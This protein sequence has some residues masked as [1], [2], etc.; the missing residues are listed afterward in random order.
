MK[1]L[2]L[3]LFLVVSTVISH[4]FQL[5]DRPISI[6]T[7]AEGYVPDESTATKIAE[8][9]LVPIYGQ[10]V[11]DSETPLRGKLESGIWTVSGMEEWRL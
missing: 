6:R 1:T 2:P 4:A 11:V 10:Q 9:I 7:P 8:A 3:L 5:D